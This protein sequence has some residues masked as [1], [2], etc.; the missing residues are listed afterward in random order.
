MTSK[1]QLR[2]KPKLQSLML[3]ISK[4]VVQ[5]VKLSHGQSR[6]KWT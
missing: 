2:N 1:N 6:L 5:T 3:Y 4:F